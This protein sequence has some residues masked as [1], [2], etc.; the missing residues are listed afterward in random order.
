MFHQLWFARHQPPQ[1]PH[2]HGLLL[3]DH[4][5]HLLRFLDYPMFISYQ[6]SEHYALHHGQ[7]SDTHSP[8]LP[9][10]WCFPSE[11]RKCPRDHREWHTVGS[12]PV[13]VP[14]LLRSNIS[15]LLLKINWDILWLYLR[16]QLLPWHSQI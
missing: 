4:L 12:Y 6:C 1:V 7:H 9:P 14:K 3:G 5:V 10:T 16:H 2:V 11:K 13:F 8:S 15:Q